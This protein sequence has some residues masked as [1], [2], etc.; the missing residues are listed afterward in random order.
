MSE[1]RVT[2]HPLLSVYRLM[3]RLYIHEMSEVM[4]NYGLT[5]MELDVL[6]FLDANAPMDTAAEIVA[7][8]NLTKSH[9]SSAVDHLTQMGY[10]VQRRDEQNRRRV[11]LIL[12]DA[13]RPVLMAGR[14]AQ[15]RFTETLYIGMTNEEIQTFSALLCRVCKNA[16]EKLEKIGE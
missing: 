4:S 11:H 12:T 13:A 16:G 15:Q 7:Q 3:K 6:L 2:N 5:R 9:V 1:E 10:L 14:D 8:R